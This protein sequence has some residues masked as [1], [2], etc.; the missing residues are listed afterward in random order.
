MLQFSMGM[1]ISDE[2]SE[3][4]KP[5]FD[6]ATEGL[7]LANDYWSW[8]REWRAFKAGE[9]KRVVNA[10]E[11]VARTRSLPIEEAQDAVKE[12]I[13]KSEGEFVRRRDELY[14]LHPT[15]STKLKRWIET[16]GLAISG[17]HYWCSACPRQNAWR[18]EE[19]TGILP[20][21][22]SAKRPNSDVD[23][24]DKFHKR[25]RASKGS[26]LYMPP[27]PESVGHVSNGTNSPK[28]VKAIEDE[29]CKQQKATKTSDY[30]MY[31]PDTMALESPCTYISSLPSKGVRATLIEALNYWMDV[32]A[33]SLKVI[34]DVVNVLHNASLI[35]DDIEDNSPLRRGKP[36]THTIFG[37]SQSIN[38]A[39]F[40][41]VKATAQVL[42]GL[43]PQAM[44][45]LLEELE[46][47]YLGQ[48]WDLYWKHNLQCPTEDEYINMIDHKT[49]G[50]FRM[51]LRLMEAES[52]LLSTFD[53]DRMTLLFGRFFQVRDDYMNFG[54]YANQKGFCEDLDEGK[55]SYPIVYCLE[56]RPEFRAHILGIFRQRPASASPDVAPLPK[57]RKM[58]ILSCLEVSGAFEATWKCMEELEAELDMEIGRLEDATGRMNPM[59]RLLL[60]RLSV[61]GIKK[62]GLSSA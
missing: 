46:G 20:K 14:R 56:H 15:L 27:S 52:P 53:F 57:E 41:Y 26:S 8:E 60:A 49:G 9:T 5:I 22:K 2:E 59:L 31:K 25:Q 12:M 51:L 28:A 44:E 4:V 10:V 13:I 17:N 33:K 48:S 43:S 7:L 45:V 40:M 11:V 58:H 54:D 37:Q 55:F 42:K 19:L 62:F 35:L 32:P 1:N 47:L 30:T 36:A 23:P 6:A 21:Q 39:N 3:L 50:M 16:C 18:Q 61:K 38:A 24:E 29:S 34:E